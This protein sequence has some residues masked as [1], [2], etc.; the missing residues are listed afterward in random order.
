MRSHS[1]KLV[2]LIVITLAP[3]ATVPLG[4]GERLA[5]RVSPRVAIAPATLIV[6]AVA[7]RDPANRA[8]QIEA[9]V[10]VFQDK[11]REIDARR[12]QPGE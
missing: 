5:M 6:D 10:A 1:T 2:L 12:C 9:W 4:A 8:L 11:V 7:E 3:L